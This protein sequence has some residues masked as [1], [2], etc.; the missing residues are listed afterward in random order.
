MVQFAKAIVEQVSLEG[1][2]VLWADT[3][4]RRMCDVG[5][6]WDRTMY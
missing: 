6:R 3:R 1:F 2:N 5:Q 4:E